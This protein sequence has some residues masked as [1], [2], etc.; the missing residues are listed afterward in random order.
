MVS[1]L[2]TKLYFPPVRPNLVP[3]PHL[4]DQLNLKLNQGSKLTLLSAPAGFGKTTLVA[5]WLHESAYQI[6][7]LSLD[8]SDNDPVRFV[9]YL[10][11]ALQKANPNVGGTIQS[12]LDTPQTPPME[13]LIGSI[14]NE[15]ANEGTQNRVVLV[16][17]DY[18][19]IEN[20]SIHKALIFLIKNQPVQLHLVITSR[21]DPPLNLSLLRGRGEITEIRL[22][23]LRFTRRE[24]ATLLNTILGLNLR[25]AQIET[26][27]ARTEGWISGLHLAAISMQGR[28]DLD[29][30]VSSF[31]G[32]N[33]Y[34]LDYLIEEVFR[35]QPA[36]IQ[37]FLLRT[38]ILEQLTAPLCDAL[39][40]DEGQ[41][42][43][44]L[45]SL[46]ILEQL[47]RTNVFIIPLDESRQWFRYHQLFAD[48][49]RHR[50]RLKKSD[51]AD[52]HCKA[53]DWFAVNGFAGQAIE[54][55]LSAGDW[56]NAAKNIL[57]ASDKLLKRGENA[58][59]VR[60]INLLPKEVMQENLKLCLNC[61]WALALSG[62][63]DEAEEYLQIVEAHAKDN[64][65]LFGNLLTAQIH[66]ARARHDHARTIELS[67]Q[68]LSML[69][70]SEYEVRGVLNLN[71]GLAL[72]QN[73]QTIA[74]QEV[75]EE[76]RTYAQQAKN[77]HA[78]LL[79][80]GLLGTIQAT[81]GNLHAAA[82][83]LR[84]AI[85]WG[86]SYPASALAYM[87][88]GMIQYEWNQLEAAN[89][90]L[91]TAISLAQR[92]GN[93][94][95]LGN[96]YR[97][98]ALLKQAL[99]DE[100]EALIALERAAQIAGESAPPLTRGRNAAAYVKVLLAQGKLEDAQLHAENMF[101]AAASSFYLLLHL[102]PARISL[103]KGDK[104]SALNHL[105]VQYERAVQAGWRYGQIEIRLLQALAAP[106]SDEAV[107]YVGDALMLAQAEGY[108]RTFLDKGE[109][110]VPWLHLAASQKIAA[111][112]AREL[113]NA[114][115]TG[116]LPDQNLTRP[117]ALQQDE[118]VE[119]LSEREMAVL[120]LLAEGQTNQE[121]AGELFVSVNTV[122]SHLKNIFGKLGV[123]N[124]REA[125]AQARVRNLLTD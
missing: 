47:E 30:F 73:G 8:E 23:D 42:H 14:I 46:I 84:Q 24:A 102:A 121:I 13:I 26:L 119:T 4:I 39:F 81:L 101:P 109:E 57:E 40:F 21:E 28:S 44:T 70:D 80:S 65:A 48:L 85:E 112:Y 53:G 43:P 20:Q 51:L 31:A 56:E 83:L 106:T 89:Q 36:E 2:A 6:A 64:P 111:S 29:S 60:W 34:V 38:S 116:T 99:G 72:W 94:E 33:R 86:K 120:R 9:S 110:L 58:T 66:I 68:V 45:N 18:H 59:L 55:Y 37:D 124:R 76:A 100:P 63:E 96:A 91:Q 108:I 118:L 35:Q 27:E 82:D 78:E 7:W 104:I 17:D 62:Q 19:L 90:S 5:D 125:V 117:P 115:G 75:L 10:S 3:R 74:A 87:D 52:L 122:K 54:H 22:A 92:S 98:W 16:L 93:I 11:A 123:N 49:L 25:A 67:Q 61:A 88:L 50:L 32:S 97:C 15:I 69:P 105:G 12:L 1:L 41:S 114:F 95:I 77:H 79:A 107:T 103:A 113:L 71:L